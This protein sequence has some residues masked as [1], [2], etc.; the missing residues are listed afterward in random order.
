MTKQDYPPMDGIEDVAARVA[1]I[2]RGRPELVVALTGSVASGKSTFALHLEQALEPAHKVDTV[3][4]DG[5]LFTTTYLRENGLFER[6]GFPDS[7][8]RAAL[9]AAIRSVRER[10]TEFPGYS[11]VTFDPDPAL[12]RTIDDPDIL[13]LEG[14]G[15]VPR[16]TDPPAPHDPDILIYLDAE[17][18]DIEDWYIQRFVRLWRAARNDPSSFYAQ[19]LH[20]DETQLIQFAR[21]VWAGINLPNLENHILPLRDHADLVVKKDAAHAVTIVA[22]RLA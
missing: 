21:T 14:V 4:T 6:K 13:I 22:D 1:E 18:A 20:M 9:Q 10:P 17:L 16:E 8:D 5:F 2:K 19:F 7:Y 11:H 12:T 3:S 15:F